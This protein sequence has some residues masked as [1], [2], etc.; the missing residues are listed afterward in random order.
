MPRT[1]ELNV[2]LS[3]MVKVASLIEENQL[4]ASILGPHE[5]KDDTIVIEVEYELEERETVHTL[6][7]FIEDTWE[8]LDEDDDE[9]DDDENDD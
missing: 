3:A 7:D 1:K 9:D 4:T 6:E 8:E 2:P 5:E